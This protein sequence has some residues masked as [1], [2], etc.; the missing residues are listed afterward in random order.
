MSQ[1]RQVS[2]DEAQELAKREGLAFIET[3]ALTKSGVDTTFSRILEEIHRIVKEQELD[4]GDDDAAAVVAD[5]EAVVVDDD[6][7]DAK[8]PSGGCCK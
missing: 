6:K 3:S 4:R 8:A 1:L 5:G 7:A 2:T